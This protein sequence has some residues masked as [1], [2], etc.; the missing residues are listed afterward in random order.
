MI[1][2]RIEQGARI[3]ATLGQALPD[4]R[5]VSD[6]EDLLSDYRKT[7]RDLRSATETDRTL[8]R[9]AV[10]TERLAPVV[11]R[12]SLSEELRAQAEEIRAQASL[13]RAAALHSVLTPRV[14]LAGL[15]VLG[16][17]IGGAIGLPIDELARNWLRPALTQEINQ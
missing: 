14:V 13:K 9:L 12:L 15:V 8:Q 6:L 2:E 3:I 7:E 10:V 4:H 11:D 5:V 17:L 1:E 16:T